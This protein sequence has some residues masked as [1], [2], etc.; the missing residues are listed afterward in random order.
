MYVHV[1]IAL[2]ALILFI[3]AKVKFNFLVAIF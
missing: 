1:C 2:D 3:Q